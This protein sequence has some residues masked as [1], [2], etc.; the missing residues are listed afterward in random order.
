MDELEAGQLKSEKQVVSRLTLAM[1]H[2][3]WVCCCLLH[4]GLGWGDRDPGRNQLQQA[5]T[6]GWMSEEDR[7]EGLPISA[8]GEENP[9]RWQNQ[10]IVSKGRDHLGWEQR[11]LF[12]EQS[13]HVQQ[14]C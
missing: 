14:T 12:P 10:P 7:A 5:Q 3:C 8:Q 1:G 11:V 2:D 13:S 9:T 6:S 4:I